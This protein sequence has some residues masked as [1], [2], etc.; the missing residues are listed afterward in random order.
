MIYLNLY[1]I[2][3]AHSVPDTL[4]KHFLISKITELPFIELLYILS[5]VMDPYSFNRKT[6]LK[7]VFLVPL[8]FLLIRARET[9]W[10]KC[11]NLQLYVIFLNYLTVSVR[12]NGGDASPFSN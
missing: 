3:S 2:S 10:S 5:T 6:V 11:C 1:H 12:S 4:Y 7:W 8:I 9:I